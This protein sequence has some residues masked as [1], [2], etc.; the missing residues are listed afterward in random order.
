M[1]VAAKPTTQAAGA[2]DTLS[3]LLVATKPRAELQAKTQLERQR[4]AVCL[5]TLTLRK[6]KRGVW[7][8]VTEAMFPGYVFVGVVLGV[9]DITPVRSTVGCLQVVRFGGQLVPLPQS[10]MNT[11][12]SYEQTPLNATKS[13]S[14][15]ERLRVE[16]GPF[17]GLEAVFD[18]PRGQDRV[19]VLVTV[20][21]SQRPVEVS[22]NALG[23]L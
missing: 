4:Y 18:K 21:G 16:E 10:V 9:D 17:Q 14:A 1:N 7:Q 3:W 22:V 6:R 15:G 20:L 12:L 11:L 2:A 19:Q 5:P 23:P 8:Q 13:F